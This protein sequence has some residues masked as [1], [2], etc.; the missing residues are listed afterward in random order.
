MK[1]LLAAGAGPIYQLTHA[2]RLEERG[3]LHNPEFTI[4]EWYRPGW[5]HPLLMDEVEELLAGLAGGQGDSAFAR[6]PYDRLTVQQAFE[7]H[8]GVDPHRA[9]VPELR[10]AA[11][12]A[13]TPPQLAEDDRDG[14]L[15][16]LQATVVE[17]KLGLE[18]PVFVHLYPA[19]Q[20]ALA[21]IRPGDPPLAERFELYV[22]GIELAN[23]F[24]ELTDSGEQRQRIRTENTA[25]EASGKPA[26]PVD[27]AFLTALDQMP[28]S[29]GVAL[30]IDR[31]VMLLLGLATI[32]DCMAFAGAVS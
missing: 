12:G 20:C 18:R 32:D 19:D 2:F 29:A 4:L 8:A 9:G 15:A 31:I 27:E 5:E 22:D 25:R 21:R 26:L 17:P 10:R 24:T 1:R 13:G 16:Y 14:W 11:S 28:P 7:R 23:G 6:Q 3:H 30:G